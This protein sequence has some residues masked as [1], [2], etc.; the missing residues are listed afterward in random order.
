MPLARGHHVRVAYARQWRDEFAAA[1]FEVCFA[2]QQIQNAEF[3]RS[4]SDSIVL[5]ES[6]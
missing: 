5:L 6:M 3:S 1:L 2:Y 4:L